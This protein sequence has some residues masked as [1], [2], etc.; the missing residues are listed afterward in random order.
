[1]GGRV[2]AVEEVAE[3][4]AAVDE[5]ATWPLSDD[6]VTVSSN[7]FCRSSGR[8]AN[9]ML[10]LGDGQVDETCRAD[11]GCDQ[12]DMREVGSGGLLSSMRLPLRLSACIALCEAAVGGRSCDVLTLFEQCYLATDQW[13]IVL[14]TLNKSSQVDSAPNQSC[15]E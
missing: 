7:G 12:C 15:A 9:S 6:G 13:L 2:W 5:G 14:P 11:A 4:D 1:M 8:R 10:R 3:G